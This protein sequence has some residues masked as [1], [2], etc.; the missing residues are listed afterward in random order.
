MLFGKRR[1]QDVERPSRFG[2]SV[3]VCFLF[4]VSSGFGWLVD[5]MLCLFAWVDIDTG[6][7]DA[8]TLSG[9]SCSK[10]NASNEQRGETNE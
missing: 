1:R 4:V 5:E 7:L 10:V 2:N 9:W 3:A 8:V 6:G